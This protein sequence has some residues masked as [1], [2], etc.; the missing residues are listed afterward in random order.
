[1]PSSF[2]ALRYL[3]H[4]DIPA[5]GFAGQEK[6]CAGSTLLVGAGGLGAAAALYLAGAGVGHIG[7]VDDD[8]IEESNLQRQIIFTQADIG[9]A[10]TEA[11]A[12]RLLALNPTI[13]VTP[14]TLRLDEKNAAALCAPYAVILDCSDNFATRYLLNEV[15]LTQKK[16][17]I[18]A[19]VQG[20]AGQGATFKGHQENHACYR[21]LFPVQPPKG[22]VPSC[23][24][25]GVFGPIVG[26]MGT[27]QAAE[28][29]KELAELGGTTTHFF[30]YD[31]QTGMS[32][33]MNV[34]KMPD[35][36]S[37]SKAI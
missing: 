25:A 34:P 8:H 27:W 13:S 20:F 12:T 9:T 37:C 17:L 6:I 30:S 22:M 2:N 33:S 23:P 14:H 7:L 16:P 1:M 5:L 29:L 21:C 4:I 19:S 35:C 15:A 18:S 10:K 11:A 32:H 31:S 28:A 24:E 3:R 36:P 26:I